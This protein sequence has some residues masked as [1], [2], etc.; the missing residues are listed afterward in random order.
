M[1]IPHIPCTLNYD[2]LMLDNTDDIV[3]YRIRCCGGERRCECK[4]LRTLYDCFFFLKNMQSKRG[5]NFAMFSIAYHKLSAS[6][7]I[8]EIAYSARRDFS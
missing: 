8:V 3:Y 4:G 6:Y 5:L 7:P 1:I 2:I